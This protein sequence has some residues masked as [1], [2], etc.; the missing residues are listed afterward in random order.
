MRDTQERADATVAPPA[1]R[2]PRLHPAL[3]PLLVLAA[4]VATWFVHAGLGTVLALVV[5][6]ALLPVGRF[7]AERV[8]TAALCFAAVVGVLFV[9]LPV[10]VTRVSATVLVLA[11]PVLSAIA[12]VRRRPAAPLRRR[13]PEAGWPDLAVLL[14]A[15][16]SAWWTLAAT[17]GMDLRDTLTRLYH[18]WDWILHTIMYTDVYRY[19]RLAGLRIDDSTAYLS[20]NPQLHPALWA[21]T[22]WSSQ[23]GSSSMP[24]EPLIQAEILATSVTAALCVAALAW[25]ATDLTTAIVGGTR[26]RYPAVVAA[27]VTGV[28]LVVGAGSAVFFFGHT[29]FLLAVSAL[30]V[31]SYLSVRPTLRGTATHAPRALVLLLATAV[32]VVLEWPPLV[33][34]L[35]VPG[36]LLAVRIARGHRRTTIALVIGG[37]AVLLG[38][39][40]WWPR[41]AGAVTIRDLAEAAGQPARFSLPLTFVAIVVT[42][43][44]AV[45]LARRRDWGRAAGILGPVLGMLAFCALLMAGGAVWWGD[46]P[47]YYLLKTLLGCLLATTPVVVAVLVAG[48]DLVPAARRSPRGSNP[49]RWVAI[50]AVTVV[51]LGIGVAQSPP[52]SIVTGRAVPLADPPRFVTYADAVARAY[53]VTPAVP[54]QAP[55]LADYGDERADLWLLVLQRGVSDADHDFYRTLPAFYPPQEGDTAES[56]VPPPDGWAAVICAQLRVR[57]EASFVAMTDHPVEVREWVRRSDAVCDTSRLSVL[58]LPQP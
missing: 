13:L 32:V 42:V 26:H 22:T 5:A 6:A 53:P 40:V 28:L 47:S 52:D 51:A 57:P 34:G 20:A 3:L 23:D 29:P 48:L 50:A 21:T 8:V 14:V 33:L 25:L 30:A 35:V 1:V 43:V 11:M 58:E 19:G 49:R 10:H 45:L 55:F 38:I 41:V 7:A 44:V 27:M 15:G 16:A 46:T 9:V 17:Y 4:V 36:L 56:V 54:S 2:R 39:P 31:G 12:S 18:G 37:A 24:G